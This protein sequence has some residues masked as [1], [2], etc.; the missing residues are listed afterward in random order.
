[1]SLTPG[2]A[3]QVVVLVVGD[4]DAG[5]SRHWASVVHQM[6]PSP[7]LALALLAGE[8]LLSLV[9]Q[10]V[11]LQLFKTLKNCFNSLSF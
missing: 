7:E 9:D 2:D 11:G 10:H 3:V 4:A 8:R 5:V 6:V 1:M